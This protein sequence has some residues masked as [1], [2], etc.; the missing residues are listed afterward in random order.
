M[1]K[2]RFWT[3][4]APLSRT[5]RDASPTRLACTDFPVNDLGRWQP[6]VVAGALVSL[7][8]ELIVL[9]TP[10]IFR[11]AQGYAL[12]TV[13]LGVIVFGLV[14]LLEP[15]AMR[16]QADPSGSGRARRWTSRR[17]NRN[18]TTP[19]PRRGK[20]RGVFLALLSVAVEW[21]RL[22]IAAHTKHR[23]SG[24]LEGGRSC[25]AYPDPQP[26]RSASRGDVG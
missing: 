24:P 22:R 14:W 17:P 19:T 3:P 15:K 2:R 20:G 7:A 25:S 18:A 9:L 16:R 21:G 6:L 8:Y 1:W 13:L 26:R 12:V 11:A 4:F 5:Y 10:D 23:P